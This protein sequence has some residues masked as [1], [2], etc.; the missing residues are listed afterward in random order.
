MASRVGPWSTVGQYWFQPT[1]TSK[2]SEWGFGL[3]KVPIPPMDK[4]AC[5]GPPEM[6]N[7]DRM[8]KLAR[9]CCFAAVLSG[10]FFVIVGIVSINHI[11][12]GT[13]YV[14]GIERTIVKIACSLAGISTCSTALVFVDVASSFCNEGPGGYWSGEPWGT[15][16]SNCKVNWEG[17]SAPLAIVSPVFWLGIT[18]CTCPILA[19]M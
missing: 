15:V 18:I 14:P 3:W 4:S 19:S 17:T 8:W 1:F 2:D 9:A 5:R 13:V 6:E 7:Y 16:S 10:V 12:K 11:V